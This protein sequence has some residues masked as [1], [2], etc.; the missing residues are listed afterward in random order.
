MCAVGHSQYASGPACHQRRLFFP[1]EAAGY[2][3]AFPFSPQPQQHARRLQHFNAQLHHP[4]CNNI[5]CLN[6]THKRRSGTSTTPSSDIAIA[7]IRAAHDSILRAH[8]FPIA[9]WIALFIAH[10]AVSFL[11]LFHRPMPRICA[12]PPQLPTPPLTTLPPPAP[13]RPTQLWPVSAME[14]PHAHPGDMWR[15]ARGAGRCAEARAGACADNGTSGAGA[16]WERRGR[17]HGHAAQTDG[18]AA[19]VATRMTRRCW[20][21]PSQAAQGKRAQP[22]AG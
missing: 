6:L 17:P 9:C 2:C 7:Q 5:F 3:P 21:A 1:A 10:T 8:V 4:G 13:P 19:W 15:G 12:T 16:G 20:R 11:S 22:A 14:N 18:R